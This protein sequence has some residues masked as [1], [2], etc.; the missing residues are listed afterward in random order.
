MGAALIFFWNATRGNRLR[1][2]RSECLKWRVETF[3]GKHAEEV[4]LKDFCFS[5]PSGDSCC[6]SCAG[7]ARCGCTRARRR[8]ADARFAQRFSEGGCD[9]DAVASGSICREAAEDYGGGSSGRRDCGAGSLGVHGAA[10]GLLYGCAVNMDALGADPAYAAMIRAQCRILV[11]ENA[12]KWKALRP[13]ADKFNFE[14]ADALVAFAEANRMK[15]RG[16][17]LVWHESNPKWL[18]ATATKENAHGLLVSHIQ[19]VAGRY[20]GRMHS[21]DVVNEAIHVADGR[22]DG[23]RNTIWLKLIGEE[24]IELAYKTAREADPQALLTYNDFGIEAETRDGEQKRAAVLEMLRRMMARRVP[25]DAVGVQSHIGAWAGDASSSAE[26]YGAGLMRF[27]AAVRELGLQ[28]F[29]TEMD[30]N[31]RALAADIASRDAAIGDSLQTIF[32]DGVERCSG[33][34]RAD[35]GDY[36]SL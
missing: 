6:D 36:G 8:R 2:W 20:T 33:E 5:T 21:W 23:L 31:D 26:Q 32:R 29:V 35:L 13:A 25:L 34:G 30:V 4:G 14:Q 3:T 18:D 15:I 19:T 1:P 24:Y 28:V 9:G 12:M 11:A 17:N 10:H 16:H 22:A 7:W 27:I